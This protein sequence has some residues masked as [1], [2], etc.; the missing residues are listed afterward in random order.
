MVKVT[1]IIPTFRRSQF[2]RCSI[3]S[4]LHQENIEPEI[5]VVDDNGEGDKYQ[6]E[7]K[8]KLADYIENNKI[9]YIS[10]DCNK[11]GSAAR[12]TGIQNSTGDFIAFLDDDDWF[13]K[14]KLFE[15]VTLMENESTDACLCGFIRVY[16]KYKTKVNI[17]EFKEDF[18][19][20]LLA[21]D[22]DTCAG[23]SLVI[24]KSLVEKVGLFDI[25]FN[26]FQDL[27]YL[28]RI[29]K[30]TKI[31][32][33]NTALV[34]IFMHSGNLIH[35][36]AKNIMT[37]HMQYLKKFQKDIEELDKKSK[38]DIID[39]HYI[40]I[41]KGF[42]KEKKLYKG[43]LWILKTTN[44]LKSICIIIKHSLKYLLL[45]RKRNLTHG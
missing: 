12:N 39:K 6:I 18:R 26:R 45:R 7:N 35:R 21:F 24:R 43:L 9:I 2:I 34:Y 41:S 42:I 28:Y 31:S 30:I 4:A 22:I 13:D 29:A 8:Q 3:D 16:E 14:N 20:Q 44:P 25:T 33:V 15:Q 17:P 32:V 5:I 40:E 38:V 37:Y 11:N 23:S 10:H 27:E 36:P 19:T 1:I